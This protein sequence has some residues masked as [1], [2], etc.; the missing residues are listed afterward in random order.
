[1]NR[2]IIIGAGGHG[3]VVAEATNK[4]CVF[5]DDN[6]KLDGV[7]GSIEQFPQVQQDGDTVVIAIGDNKTR[8]EILSKF[9]HAATV[10]HPSAVIS[11]SANIG[12]GTVVF[13]NVVVNA[14]AVIGE[15]CILNTASSVDHGCILG[16]GVHI[17]PG[18]HL[19]GNVTVGNCS[20]VG[21]GA[22]VKHGVTIGKSVMV[23]AGAAVV[24][25]ISDGVTVVGVPAREKKT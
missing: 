18:A 24:N 23:G 11:E 10:I 7:V 25:D 21:I 17:S 12:K 6:Q 14:G 19:G 4:A 3:R 8:M 2:L 5:L 20:W 15:G 16:D 22:S 13:A 9:E 1:M